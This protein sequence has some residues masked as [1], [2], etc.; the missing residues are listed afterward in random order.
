M[1]TL[2]TAQ[3][4]NELSILVRAVSGLLLFFGSLFMFEQSLDSPDE[5]DTSVDLIKGGQEIGA[6]TPAL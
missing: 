3:K 4:L 5:K 1:K 2:Q 6:W